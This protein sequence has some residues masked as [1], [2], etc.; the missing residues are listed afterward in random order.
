MKKRG[1]EFA[2]RMIAGSAM[3]R[4][5]RG[6]RSCILSELLEGGER[7][8]TIKPTITCKRKSS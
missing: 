8:G 1:P 3:T 5:P 4:M 2:G 6:H 7:K